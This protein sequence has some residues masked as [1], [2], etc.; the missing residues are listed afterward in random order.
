[1]ATVKF[2]D[3]PFANEGDVTPV[4]DSVQLDGS[5]S[6][7]EGYGPDYELDPDASGV[8]YPER[9]GMNW[10]FYAITSALKQWQT[11]GYPDFITSAD[12]GG[13]PW[14]YVKNAY[15]RWTD[16]NIYISLVDA[17]IADPTDPS[18]W[19]Q[20]NP[21]PPAFQ[22]GDVMM[23]EST[24]LRTGGWVW[25]NGTTVG[26]ASSNAT[27]RANAD[28]ST[29]FTQ[30]W[31][32]FPNSVRPIVNSDGS[33]GTRGVS[34]AADYSAHKALPVRDMRDVVAAGTATMGGTSDRG[35][36]TSAGGVDGTV[37]GVTGGAQQITLDTSQ[38]PNLNIPAQTGNVI[39]G[40]GGSNNNF[41]I[42]DF[43]SGSPT[44]T[45]R[46]TNNG[47]GGP[48]RNVQPTTICNFIVK[49]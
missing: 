36:L 26:D 43:S 28:T 23:W 16:G 17:N 12:N 25:A 7:Q 14:P 10:M 32:N 1:M 8:L 31:T 34:A 19:T 4:P 5:I 47:G 42:F 3:V 15:V 27:G 6:F 37:F 40:Q 18:K 48:H 22:T 24:T 44:P 41:T 46:S 30:I 45:N 39:S 33:P 21:F 38:V 9:G 11:Q 49:L 13:T 20:F 2:F 29:L 35:L